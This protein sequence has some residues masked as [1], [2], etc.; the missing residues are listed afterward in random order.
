M[1]HPNS[2][3]S[4]NISSSSSSNNNF[5][6]N[7]RTPISDYI[8]FIN[9]EDITETNSEQSKDIVDLC[10]EDTLN[11]TV[12]IEDT[13]DL[14]NKDTTVNIENIAVTLAANDE[15][16][17]T[18]ASV[19]LEDVLKDFD[20]VTAIP[21]QTSRESSTLQRQSPI[22][23]INTA[24]SEAKNPL[25]ILLH[26]S[27]SHY[28]KLIH[29]IHRNDVVPL[30][31]DMNLIGK[32]VA[33]HLLNLATPPQRK[34]PVITLIKWAKYFKRLFP[35]TPTSAFYAFRYEP[36]RRPNGTVFQRKRAEGVLQVQLFQERRKLIKHNRNVLL[37]KPS[38]SIISRNRDPSSSRDTFNVTNTRK[39]LRQS[40]REIK[41]NTDI[42][43][44]GI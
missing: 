23:N 15:E 39:T 38:E 19:Q 20:E 28:R 12:N 42:L 17:F 37:R 36:Y 13:I 44:E 31:P 11:T 2:F 10:I 9:C 14:C 18:K 6:E 5:A 29:N 24:D 40:E 21:I 7:P 33:K 43:K 25:L 27:G 35:K 26:K 16:D 8:H 34:I 22:P 32:I 3:D 4:T 41:S 30:G 1:H